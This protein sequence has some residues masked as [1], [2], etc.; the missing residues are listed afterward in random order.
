LVE[1][2]RQALPFLKQKRSGKI[3]GR[4]CADGLKQRIY[5]AKGESTSPTVSVE[6]LLLTCAIDAKEGRDVA[7]VDIPGAFTQADM[8]DE[9]IHVRL[10]GRMA[11]RMTENDPVYKK[12]VGR[13]R[14]QPVLY[15]RLLK[16]L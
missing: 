6:A 9:I 1:G 5:T 10:H 8:D 4:R 14:D 3:K 11:E 7:T 2:K 13:E 16:A 12:Y 15:I